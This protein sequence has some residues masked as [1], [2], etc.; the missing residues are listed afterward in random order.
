[1]EHHRARRGSHA[2]LIE[3]LLGYSRISHDDSRNLKPIELDA[4]VRRTLD[5]LGP[6]LQENGATV[7]I[8]ILP[9]VLGDGERMFICSRTWSRTA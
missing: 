3:D 2:Q 1:M 7:N 5:G 4:I 6:A 9:R 8:G